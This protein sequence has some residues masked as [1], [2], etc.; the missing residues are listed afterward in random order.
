MARRHHDHTSADDGGTPTDSSGPVTDATP[1]PLPRPP[2][3]KAP[4]SNPPAV[5]RPPRLPAT[6]AIA[7]ARPGRRG[8]TP[9]DMQLTKK[10]PR[11]A[12][13]DQTPAP[14]PPSPGARDAE[15]WFEQVPTNPAH[16]A[17]LAEQTGGHL[18]ARGSTGKVPLSQPVPIAER[19]WLL[20]TLIAAI[21]LTI[22]M[23]LG[24]L[25]FGG[26]GE[27]EPC[28]AATPPADQGPK[29]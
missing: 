5:P 25:L 3:A 12:S 19:A 26:D 17:E 6:P 1:A 27:C 23:I 15:R 28:E 29:Q 7:P 16:A 4:T 13:A 11:A 21:A 22:G 2:V 10:I 9:S 8:E 20:P 24:G 18:R 14:L